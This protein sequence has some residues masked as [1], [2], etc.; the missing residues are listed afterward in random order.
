MARGGPTAAKPGPR[1]V[2]I[3]RALT[4]IAARTRKAF[5]MKHR[6]GRFRIQKTVYL[7][8]RLGYGPAREYAFNLY[9]MG[10]YSRDLARDYYDL[11]DLGLH[12][13]GPADDI[14]DEMAKTVEDALRVVPAAE[15]EWEEPT[16]DDFL[17]GLSTA[18]DMGRR[19]VEADTAIER[20][21]AI[22]PSL[23]SE[24]WGEVRRF[25]ASH[26][27]LTEGT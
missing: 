14:P 13:A 4:V 15:D 25:L 18:I 26:P 17:E 21:K 8:R 24:A 11:Q 19:G 23:P 1:A 16:N 20:A 27:G 2:A 10:P 3:A 9:L 7:L 12:E 5:T 22:K 6:G